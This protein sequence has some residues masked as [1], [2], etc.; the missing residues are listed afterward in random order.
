MSHIEVQPFES[1]QLQQIVDLWQ[2]CELTRPWNDP[3]HDIHFC[4][5]SQDSELLVLIRD[6]KV[7]GS[8]MVGHD[9][10]RGWVYY[11][12]VSPVFQR[13][14]YGAFLLESAEQWL[15]ENNV[16]KLNVMI[17]DGNKKAISF[18]RRLGFT[19]DEVVVMSKR[20][21]DPRGGG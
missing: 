15:R 10:H 16:P 17:R 4:Q 1:A 14:G 11:L 2:R 20:Y 6:G 8:V 13:S 21:F 12:A 9:G 19:Q 7:I 5:Q 3:V 18:Y